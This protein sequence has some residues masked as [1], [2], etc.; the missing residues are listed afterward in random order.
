[1]RKQQRFFIDQTLLFC[2]FGVAA[3]MAQTTVTPPPPAVAP[4]A[5]ATPSIVSAP[6][7]NGSV[8]PGESVNAPAGSTVKTTVSP[9]AS[10]TTTTN[11]NGTT[12]TNTQQPPNGVEVEIGIAD[13][14]AGS[15]SG[16]SSANGV[17]SL[18]NLGRSTPQLLTGLG[19]SCDTSTS[20]T[21]TTTAAGTAKVTAAPAPDNRFCRSWAN[22]LG[23]FISV[24]LGS[25]TT[26]TIT[27]YS[28][29][30]T[31]AVSK[32]LRVLAGFSMSPISQISPGF[33]N[34]AAQYVTKNPTLFPGINAA[35]L[36]ANAPGAFD[37]IQTTTTAPGANAAPTATIYY[38][39]S[40]TE[41]NYKPGLV[42]G[43]ALPINIWN[44][45]GGNNKSN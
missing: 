16:Y 21:T 32:Y 22:H 18:T 11:N 44:L 17:L 20:T 36:A 37:G 42:I 25:G 10:V 19:F 31:F 7:T 26:Q 43:V 35:N 27:G 8:K 2:A 41:I 34:A 38:P 28:M 5:A 9:G 1:M 12:T 4:A 45:I 24:Q 40:T 39:G 3:T 6:V 33:A 13:R 23:A 29:G 30:M 14:I 15:T